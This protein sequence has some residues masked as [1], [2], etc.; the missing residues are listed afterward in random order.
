MADILVG[1]AIE[2]QQQ[3]GRIQLIRRPHS[4][5]VPRDYFELIPAAR[6]N[7]NVTK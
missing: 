6:L 7:R 5:V 2:Y 1:E 4:L 3:G